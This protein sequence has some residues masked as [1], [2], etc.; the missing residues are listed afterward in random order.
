M[1]GDRLADHVR[2]LL[3]VALAEAGLGA[4]VQVADLGQVDAHQLDG[5]AIGGQPVGLTTQTRWSTGV[6]Q[7]GAVALHALEAVDH[8]Q[9]RVQ[10]PGQVEQ[11]V[12]DRRGSRRR[13]RSACRSS[14]PACAPCPSGSPGP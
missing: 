10:T 3:Q 11:V 14:R 7:H 12:V 1:P 9:V 2:S 4:V 13:G 5:H 8:G 6:P